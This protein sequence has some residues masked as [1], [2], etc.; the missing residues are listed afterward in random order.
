MRAVTIAAAANG[1]HFRLRQL[2][3]VSSFE[4]NPARG[5][6]TRRLKQSKN[7]ERRD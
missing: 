7:G 5:N 6:F 3:Q 4:E 1:S 2:Q